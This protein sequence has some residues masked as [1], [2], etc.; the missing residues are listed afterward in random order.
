MRSESQDD[1]DSS[2]QI[3][4]LPWTVK[5]TGR[6]EL[7]RRT[8]WQRLGCV[9]TVT[10][11][12]KV[13]ELERPEP[14]ALSALAITRMCPLLNRTG[15]SQCIMIGHLSSTALCMQGV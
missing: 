9:V 10:V 6:D 8:L 15:G 1:P 14:M 3:L 7:H 4:D 12:A 11:A 2:A 13:G 5:C